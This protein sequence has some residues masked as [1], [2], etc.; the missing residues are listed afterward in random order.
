MK[1]SGANDCPH[2]GTIFECMSMLEIASRRIMPQ[3]ELKSIAR[4]GYA[5]AL[6]VGFFSHLVRRIFF[7]FGRKIDLPAKLSSS[8]SSQILAQW[9]GAPSRKNHKSFTPSGLFYK[10]SVSKTVPTWADIAH[11]PSSRGLHLRLQ[12]M[13]TNHAVLS[14]CAPDCQIFAAGVA[15][16]Q[17]HVEGHMPRN[18]FVRHFTQLHA[19][20]YSFIAFD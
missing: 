19:A 9:G 12:R 10:F 11:H 3:K 17:R 18:A 5:K 15:S 14:N 4:P 2:S 1:V 20:Q 8:H 16:Q 7:T 13:G 6:V